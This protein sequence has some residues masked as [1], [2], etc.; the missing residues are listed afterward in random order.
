MRS[1]TKLLLLWLCC[2]ALFAEPAEAF[3][4]G[5]WNAQRDTL[6]IQRSA[7]SI[8]KPSSKSLPPSTS[9]IIPTTRLHYKGDYLIPNGDS[10][11]ASIRQ[12]DSHLHKSFIAQ[13]CQPTSKSSSFLRLPPPMPSPFPLSS[14]TQFHSKP[15]AL[16]NAQQEDYQERIQDWVDVYTSVEGLRNRFGVNSNR[17]WGD[18]NPM[19]ARR[20]YQTLL[21]SALLWLSQ[22]GVQPQ[23]LAPLAYQARKAA[24]LYIRE[25]SQVPAR[26]G[27][28]LFDGLRQFRNYGKFQ[29]QGMTYE[30]VWQKY[31]Q[32]IMDEYEQ[33]ELSTNLKEKDVAAQVCYKI[34]EK[35][36]TTNSY[37]DELFASSHDEGFGEDLQQISKILEADVHRLLD[38]IVDIENTSSMSAATTNANANAKAIATTN[39]QRQLTVKR[40]HMLKRIA[41]VKR[42]LLLRSKKYKALPAHI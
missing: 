1:Q 11:L 9:T 24:K 4:A 38:P 40:Y 15:E 16:A 39:D 34:L 35:S 26:V 33:Q 14:S 28:H 42:K 10:I 12:K 27:A 25:R 5:S 32:V 3:Q 23:D 41:R 18:L 22:T 21:P 31:R 19:T 17:L 29:T 8:T 6:R 30:Q 7:S 20:I 2:F 36:C 13:D 37:I